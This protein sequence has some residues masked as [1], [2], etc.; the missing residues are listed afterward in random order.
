[1]TKRKKG[2]AGE[3]RLVSRLEFDDVA[4]EVWVIFGAGRLGVRV[5]LI[6]VAGAVA[7]LIIA[8]P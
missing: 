2:G 8:M 4:A 1:M 3:H 5:D 6:L 7:L